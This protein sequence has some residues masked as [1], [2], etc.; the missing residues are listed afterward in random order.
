MLFNGDI[1]IF[2]ENLSHSGRTNRANEDAGIFDARFGAMMG[3]VRSVLEAENFGAGIALEGEEIKL[4]AILFTTMGT[5]VR[6][7]F[8]T[9]HG[10]QK[11]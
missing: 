5:Q 6:K 1:R 2:I 4:M 7:S 3:G 8:G 11:C 9:G 10:G